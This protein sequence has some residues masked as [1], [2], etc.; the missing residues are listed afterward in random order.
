[1]LCV[2]AFLIGRSSHPLRT[3]FHLGAT[4][5]TSRPTCPFEFA[6]FPSFRPWTGPSSWSCD[7]QRE[8][9]KID[10][11]SKYRH[12]ALEL[13]SPRLAQTAARHRITNRQINPNWRTGAR[14]AARRADVPLNMLLEALSPVDVC[15]YVCVPIPWG[16]AC[17][18][19]R[20]EASQE[21]K[22]FF[23]DRDSLP[24]PRTSPRRQL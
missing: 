2:K 13:I 4:P 5:S 10:P 8:K 1:M 11:E 16:H 22:P 24:A 23:D 6:D 19:S 14:S 15:V 20:Q 12:D 21:N 7:F 18:P 9:F 17:E 3:A